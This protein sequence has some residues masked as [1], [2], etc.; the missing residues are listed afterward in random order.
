MKYS[1]NVQPDEGDRRPSNRVDRTGSPRSRDTETPEGLEEEI[2]PPVAPRITKRG[3]SRA[4][5]KIADGAEKEA[6]GASRGAQPREAASAKQG[7]AGKHEGAG[8]ES[9]H[10]PRSDRRPRQ[11]G[12]RRTPAKK[13]AA[14][15]PTRQRASDE[16][17]P[18]PRRGARRRPRRSP[19]RKR[20]VEAKAL[21]PEATVRRREARRGAGGHRGARAGDRR[22]P[23]AGDHRRNRRPRASG[24]P[25]SRGALDSCSRAPPRVLL[26]AAVVA[27]AL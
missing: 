18:R 6:P 4:K 5:A 9:E 26:L 23:G 27:F 8:A 1:S 11:R 14:A 21:A 20:V 24:S 17:G 13:P 12:E 3:A 25:A 2:G 10:S 16:Q 22:T 19:R 7:A 15:K